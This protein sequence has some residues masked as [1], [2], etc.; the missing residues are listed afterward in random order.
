[1]QNNSALQ[2]LVVQKILARPETAAD[3]PRLAAWACCSWRSIAAHLTPV[4]GARGMHALFMRSLQ[5]TSTAYPWLAAAQDIDTDTCVASLGAALAKH[6]IGQAIAAVNAL[7]VAFIE[8]LASLIG[9]SL[10]E[11]LLQLAWQDQADM[12]ARAA[13]ES[14]AAI[15]Q[16]KET[17][18]Q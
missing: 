7:F 12:H 15:T 13:C 14:S 3:A 18:E 1:M 4:I 9:E 8:L 5:L 11:Q 10:T 16:T 2:Y 17:S 6:D